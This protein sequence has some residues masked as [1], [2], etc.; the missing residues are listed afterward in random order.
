[1]EAQFRLHEPPP[2][3]IGP[4]HR[5]STKLYVGIVDFDGGLKIINFDA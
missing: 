5:M 3:I 1:M 4:V 2:L